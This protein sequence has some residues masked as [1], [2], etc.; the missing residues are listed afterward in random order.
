MLVPG[1]RFAIGVGLF[2]LGFAAPAFIPIVTASHLS[3]SWKAGI[4]GLLVLGLPEIMMI[5]A[6]AVMGK[7][8]LAELKRRLGRLLHRYGPS[9]AVSPT[10]YRIG[11]VMFVAPLLVGWLGPYLGDHLPGYATHSL[12]WSISGD[13]VF[14]ASFFVLG[15]DFWDKVRSLFVHRARAVL[16][17]ANDASQEGSR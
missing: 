12:S 17:A 4:S 16:P 11:L 3:S 5:A 7:S 6:T 15:G 10:R 14:L 13:L 8:G 9:D 2:V 1:H